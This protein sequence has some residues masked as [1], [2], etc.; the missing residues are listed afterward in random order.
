MY[1]ENSVWFQFNY[2]VFRFGLSNKVGNR[3]I[4]EVSLDTIWFR[5]GSGFRLIWVELSKT[6]DFLD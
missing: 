6:L 4:S 5:F 1:L 2:F 3:L